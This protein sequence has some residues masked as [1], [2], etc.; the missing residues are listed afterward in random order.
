ME[1]LEL[2][3]DGKLT[4]GVEPMDVIDPATEDVAGRC[5]RASEAQLDQAV[6]AAEAAQP[7]WADKSLD[8]RRAAIGRVAQIVAEHAEEI[9][10]LLTREQGK[11]LKDA[12]AEV[13]GFAAFTGY[14][15]SLDLP[16]E[17]LDD[18]PQRRVEAHRVPL[19]VV[20]AIVPWNF[21][22]ILLAFKF[23]P[24]LLAGNT[25]VVKPAPT[26]PL[27]TLRL[28]AL[29]KDAVPPGVLN[30]IADANDLG[31]ALSTHPAVRKVSFTGST[32]TGSKIMAS[33][34]STLKRLTLEMGGNDAG[35]VLPDVDPKAVAPK[36]FDAAFANNGQLCIA[37]KR[38]YVHDSIYDAVCEELV[39]IAQSKKVGSG[40]EDGVELGPIQ[41]RA[42]YEKFL[43]ILEDAKTK[44]KVLTG[45]E[46]RSGPGYF[47]EPTLVR[48]IAE[49]ARLV[50]EEQFGP[51]L[52]IVR[53][54]DP[55]EV[56][57]RVNRSESG[58]GGSVWSSDVERAH[59][60]ACRMDAGTVWVNQHAALDPSIP[61]SGAKLSGVG[62]ELGRMGL[63]EFTQLKIV[64]VARSA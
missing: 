19:G 15:A 33:A 62:A 3:I 60:L 26:T 52:P 36:L 45:G 7:G 42:Q 18:S 61:F 39:G 30:V 44:G 6:R 47:V 63:E 5:W 56:I 10:A 59:D 46:P 25:L 17:V 23:G 16:V 55:D 27:S 64:N 38:L 35:V 54:S 21:P 51:A 49:G 12:I 48:D 24:A 53:Y 8:E 28:A 31:P 50:D 14:F 29:V 41:N 32:A 22:I 2:L 1:P 9:G 20:A 43:A 13:H 37:L 11:P 34:A 58:L 40:F 57:R 4:P